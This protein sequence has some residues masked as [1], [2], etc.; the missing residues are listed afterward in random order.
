MLLM[1]DKATHLLDHVL[2]ELG[3]LTEVP[4]ATAGPQLVHI[5]GHLVGL[6]EA[7]AMG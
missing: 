1:E 3:M 4:M 7:M 5:L 6:L 2:H